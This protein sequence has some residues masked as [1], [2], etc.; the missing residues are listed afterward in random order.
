WA[1]LRGRPAGRGGPLRARAR[2]SQGSVRVADARE[3]LRARGRAL[4][5]ED[6]V[7]VR[8]AALLGDG[9]PGVRQRAER[10][11]R[12]RAGLGARG[13]DLV[14]AERA[15][16]DPRIDLGAPEALHT[17]R[18]L[19]HHPAVAPGDVGVAHEDAQTAVLLPVEPV[20]PAPLV[21]AVVRAEPRAD[22]AVVGH[23][24]EAVGAVR[25]RL[26]RADVLA[27]RERAV[28]T[29]HRLHRDDRLIGA[30]QDVA[31]DAQP[32]HLALV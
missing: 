30:A 3:L 17:V 14:S 25:R 4:V 6:R 32:V 12:H 29:R 28:L 9:R 7:A 27:R 11:R 21:G 18:A 13:A 16:G 22:A 20:E 19:L 26:D 31:I 15:I 10:D 2:S 1:A 8:P 23:L 5:V 24:V